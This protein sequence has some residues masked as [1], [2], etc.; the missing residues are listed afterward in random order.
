MEVKQSTEEG[1]THQSEYKSSS[2]P[3]SSQPAGG[4]LQEMVN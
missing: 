3:A 4:E 2:I 1:K